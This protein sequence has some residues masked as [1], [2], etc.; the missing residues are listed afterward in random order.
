VDRA[1]AVAAVCSAVD[2][3]SDTGVLKV[4]GT[5]AAVG[6]PSVAGVSGSAVVGSL[7]LLA[8]LRC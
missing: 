1:F 5:P 8:Y 7:L 3:P 6:V 2:V 4:S